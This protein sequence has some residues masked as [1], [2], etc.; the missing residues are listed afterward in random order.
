MKKRGILLI[1]SD[2]QRKRLAQIAA[3]NKYQQKIDEKV[4]N[5]KDRLIKEEKRNLEKGEKLDAFEIIRAHQSEIEA[6][7]D[8]LR[9]SIAPILGLS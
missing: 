1:Y 5:Y 9:S 8:T 6:Y 2:D 3:R 4:E 7:S